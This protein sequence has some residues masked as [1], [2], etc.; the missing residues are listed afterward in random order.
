MINIEE[1]HLKALKSILKKYPYKFYAFG[2]RIKGDNRKYSDLDLCYKENI[3]TNVLLDIRD[4]FENS[5]LPFRVDLVFWN[6]FSNEYKKLISKYLTP[7][8]H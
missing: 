7:I 5:D 6:H 2:S 3:P 4:E 1:R 8:I